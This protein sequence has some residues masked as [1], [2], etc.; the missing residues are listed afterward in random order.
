LL[1]G[2]VL[3]G[4]ALSAWGAVARAADPD[5]RFREATAL[6]RAG[7]TEGAVAIYRQLA[8]SGHESGSLY[9]NWAQAAQGRGALG[10]ALWALMRER[11]VEPGDTA[12]G[13]EIERLRT[14]LNLDPAELS[15]S[16]LRSC[17]PARS[18]RTPSRASR[19]RSGDRW[20]QHGPPSRSGRSP[21]S[22][23][24]SAP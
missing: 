6:A 1:V 11:E 12:A 20:R 21:P 18:A 14:V 4:V 23:F 9:W 5:Q 8:V 7:D 13:R 24:G 10:E 22:A 19:A 17:W 3:A 2:A 15:P 16:P